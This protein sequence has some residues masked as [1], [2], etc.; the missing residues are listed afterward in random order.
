[1][2]RKR[3]RG[4]TLVEL[5]VVVTGIAI[6]AALAYP[7]YQSYTRQTRR[8]EAQAALTEAAAQQEQF[9]L[10]FKTYASAMTTMN[11]P[12][13]T[14]GGHYNLDVVPGSASATS[15]IL[16]ATP[17]GSQASDICGTMTL[18]QG[19]TRTPSADCW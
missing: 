14:T 9:F 5:L 7:S 16:R 3:L 2:N 8:A 11:M 19:G 4:L 18:T 15:Y 6:L 17:V 10:N 13:A 12:T 1:M